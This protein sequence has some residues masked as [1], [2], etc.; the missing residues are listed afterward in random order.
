MK[1]P[2]DNIRKYLHDL[3]LSK[4]FFAP[5]LKSNEKMSDMIPAIKEIPI[6]L[7]R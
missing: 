2:E 7:K 4:A 6:Q 3:E 5:C 1:F